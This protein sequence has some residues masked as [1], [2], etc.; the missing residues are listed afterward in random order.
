M[1]EYNG[2][3]SQE[4]WEEDAADAFLAAVA[5]DRQLDRHDLYLSGVTGKWGPRC[6]RQGLTTR[7]TRSPQAAPYATLQKPPA[8]NPLSTMTRNSRQQIRRSIRYY[9]QRGSLSVDRAKTVDQ[10]LEWMD[11]LEVLHTQSWRQ[12][13]KTGA[14]CDPSFKDFHR[15]LI[16][17][18]FAEGFPDILCARA[19]ES[20]LGYLY[21]LRWQGIAYSYQS[22]F[23]YEKDALARPGLVTHVLAMQKYGGEGMATYRFLAGDA[24]YKN[25]LA[26]GKDELFWMVAYHPSM[27]RW[28]GHAASSVYR[29]ITRRS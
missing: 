28:F 16:S 23:R 13:G 19:G 11:A 8:A 10:A 18:S 29:L 22:G 17:A 15:Q 20:I 9:E 12:R 3:L 2:L 1:I 25:S 5:A 4:G 14:F 24:R 21:N 7:P 27:S 26:T 6:L